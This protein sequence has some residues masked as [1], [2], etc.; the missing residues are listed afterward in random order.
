MQGE[1]KYQYQEEVGASTLV[2]SQV[3][4]NDLI[5]KKTLTYL[6]TALGPV[7]TEL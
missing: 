1:K 7:N 3:H 5:I 4:I 6:N 2:A